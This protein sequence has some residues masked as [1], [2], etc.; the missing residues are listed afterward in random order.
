MAYTP[1]AGSFSLFKNDRKEQDNHPDYK[2]DGADLDGNP[3]WISAW[4]KKTDKSTFM[5]CSFKL[6]EQQQAKPAAK[7]NKP[8]QNGN[9]SDINDEIPF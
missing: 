3:I 5:S 6:K 2:G 8:I 9:L 4:L 1:K 7:V